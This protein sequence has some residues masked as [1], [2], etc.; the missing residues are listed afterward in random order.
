MVALTGNSKNN[1]RVRI[2]DAFKEDAGRGI[3]RIDPEIINRLNLKS[4]D[5]IEIDHL[6]LE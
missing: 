4:G 2:K 3:I 1:K 5:I 6:D